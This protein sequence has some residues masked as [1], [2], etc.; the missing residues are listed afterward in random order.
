MS[1]D[2]RYALRSLYRRPLFSLILISILAIGLGANTAM[3]SVV[4]SVLLEPLPYPEADRLVWM[5]GLTAD[6]QDNTVSA[7]DYMDYRVES[8][9]WVRLHRGTSSARWR[10]SRFSGA[11]SCRRTKTRPRATRWC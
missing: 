8:T 2:L 9:T 3:F 11:A 5:W 7:L 1:P 10:P 6:G 4:D